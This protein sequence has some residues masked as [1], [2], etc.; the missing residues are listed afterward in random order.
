MATDREIAGIQHK[1]I[2]KVNQQ[3]NPFTIAEEYG[4]YSKDDLTIDISYKGSKELT[5]DLQKW[6][7]KLAEKNVGPHYKACS[8]GWQPKFKQNDMKRPWAKFLIAKCGQENAG[9][10]MFR[11]DMD[12]GRSVIY[13]YEL[14]IDEKYQNKGL[15]EHFM[16]CLE[17]LAKV[18]QMERI[19]L[20]V[21]TNN[22]GALRFYKRL[23]YTVDETSPD[24]EPSYQIFSKEV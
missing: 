21:L 20:T 13:C 23:G 22:D 2:E 16:K 6:C 5:K 15:G 19:V 7:F 12:Y 9:Y 1:N 8:L 4:K 3:K 17:K 18:W 24:D 14:Q 10:T 11:F